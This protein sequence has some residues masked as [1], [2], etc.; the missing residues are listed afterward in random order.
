M[1]RI[2]L[3]ILGGLALVLAACGGGDPTPDVAPDRDDTDAAQPVDEDSTEPADEAVAPVATDGPIELTASWTG[4]SADTIQVGVAV[5]DAEA[6]LAFGVDL[7][8]V[9]PTKAYPALAA[10]FNE[11]GGAHGRDVEVTVEPFLPVGSVDSDRV[12]SVLAEDIGVFL[13]LGQML[14][15]NP[16]CFTELNDTPYVGAFGLTDERD[17]RSDGQFYS[18]QSQVEPQRRDSLVVLDDAGVFDGA[19]VGLFWEDRKSVG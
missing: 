2:V 14:G 15:D 12:C 8:F 16:L 10:A 11:S 9:D 7:G 17:R 13:V 3:V 18:Y 1:N 6:L 4:V 5:I 19:R